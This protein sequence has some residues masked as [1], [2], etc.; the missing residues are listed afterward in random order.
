[1]NRTVLFLLPI[2]LLLA[3][4]SV[5]QEEGPG[6]TSPLPRGFRALQLGLSLEAA[7]EILEGEPNFLFRGEPDVSLL[8]RPNESLI[9]SRGAGYIERGIFQFHEKVLYSITLV[10]DPEM[11]DFSTIFAALVEKYGPFLSLDPTTVRWENDEVR[12]FLE[13]PCTLKYLYWPTFEDIRRRA[14]R[15]ESLRAL[16]KAEFLD[17]L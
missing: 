8:S 7:R 9:D 14:V 17:Q 12:L 5:P 13:K 2:C 3:F 4:S 11:M 16:S 6:D 10:F 1:M 15:E